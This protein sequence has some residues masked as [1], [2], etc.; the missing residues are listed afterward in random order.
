MTAPRDSTF[1]VTRDQRRT[2]RMDG[3]NGEWN[4]DVW[5]TATEVQVDPSKVNG[6]G[7]TRRDM[8]HV[9]PELHVAAA[10]PRMCPLVC[11][12]E[13]FGE[14]NFCD[15]CNAD[16]A[17]EC[18]CAGEYRGPLNRRCCAG[19]DDSEPDDDEYASADAMS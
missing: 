8:W 16:A 11:Y 13:V 3:H 19:S 17:D 18:E 12:H 2:K 14:D 5:A 6:P 10:T 4:R 7:G 1:S 15:F 9:P